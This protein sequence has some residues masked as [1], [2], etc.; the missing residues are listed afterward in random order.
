MGILT[1]GF[2]TRGYKTTEEIYDLTGMRA[3]DTVFDT[4]RK[5]RRV[6]DGN[7]WVSGN[8][9]TR[10]F[11][12]TQYLS[13]YT[14]YAKAGQNVGFYTGVDDN[15][16]EIKS[17]LG[18]FGP[19]S[20]SIIGLIQC[21]IHRSYGNNTPVAVQYSG[22][23]YVWAHTSGNWRGR[24]IIPFAPANVT[25]PFANVGWNDDQVSQVLNL[26]GVFTT[27]PV[28]T[29]VSVGPFTGPVYF[30]K[31]FIRPSES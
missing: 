23:G 7:L 8:M 31:G 18:S 16:Q 15:S 29:T 4:T 25:V 19:T 13:T 10:V 17:A 30:A 14:D 3:G 6:Y 2:Y 22:E 12:T 24:Y 11:K 28:A 21:P 5:E 27:N 26:I 1:N 20:Q 9:I